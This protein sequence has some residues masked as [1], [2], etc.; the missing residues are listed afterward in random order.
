MRLR[1]RRRAGS[2]RAWKPRPSSA[3]VC[4]SMGSTRT[5]QH[6]S[7]RGSDFLGT[8]LILTDIDSYGNVSTFADIREARMS[9]V[10]LAINVS[11]LDAAV[12]F[13]SKLFAVEPA[14]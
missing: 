11:D 3:A 12:H 1:S 13:Y 2:A 6:S 8:D 7:N 14:K 10:Q 4:S 9:R 5:E